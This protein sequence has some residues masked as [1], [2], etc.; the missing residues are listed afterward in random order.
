MN[1]IRICNFC[2]AIPVKDRLDDLR[3][4]VASVY[5]QT[6]LP[7]ELIIVDDCS[8]IPVMEE[9]LPKRPQELSLRIIRNDPNLGGA[10]SLNIAAA[11][12]TQPFIAF[13]DSDDFFLPEYLERV[14]LSWD[15]VA[16]D[17]VCIGT[18][19][20]WCT[21]ALIPYRKQ[22]AAPNVTR[23][24]L[25]QPLIAK[26]QNHVPDCGMSSR[27]ARGCGA[28]FL[29]HTNSQKHQNSNFSITPS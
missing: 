1:N 12:A 27:L 8:S 17:V 22:F 13:L 7:R 20:F 9:N 29:A 14:S 5:A 24:T 25:P 4:A 15:N 16:S 18:G 23:H 3:E 28:A 21:D 6:I 26:T 19:L 11:T 2:V 10:K